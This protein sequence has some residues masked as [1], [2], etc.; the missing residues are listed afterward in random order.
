MRGLDVPICAHND[1]SLFSI[2]TENV[3]NEKQTDA[4]IVIRSNRITKSTIS[5]CLRY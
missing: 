2:S 1:I 4:A 5:A 3:E